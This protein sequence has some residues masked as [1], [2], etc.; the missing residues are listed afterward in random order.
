MK[1]KKHPNLKAALENIRKPMH[2]GRKIH[3]FI[4][5]NASKIIHFQNCC[6]HPGE[7]GC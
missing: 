2:F 7:P 6:G 3:L 5:N 4:R 1:N